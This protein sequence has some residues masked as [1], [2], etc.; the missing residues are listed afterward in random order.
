MIIIEG[1]AGSG[2]ARSPGEVRAQLGRQKQKREAVLKTAMR[3]EVEARGKAGRAIIIDRTRSG[4]DYR[5][6]RFG[7]YTERYAKQ[8]GVSPSHVTLTD[9]GGF[10][11]SLR[12]KKALGGMRVIVEFDHR[13]HRRAHGLAAGRWPVYGKWTAMRRPKRRAMGFENELDR[14]N[15]QRAG[16]K[17]FRRVM[18][19]GLR[20]PG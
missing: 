1:P 10:L 19:G 2:T 8:K 17:V 7:P 3:A 9:S 14:H 13:Y 16:W 15:L 20:Y 6:Q 18:A 5:R 11:N 12:M 4:Q